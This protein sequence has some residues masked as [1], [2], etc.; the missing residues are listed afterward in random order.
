MKVTV[1]ESD[2]LGSDEICLLCCRSDDRII[3]IVSYIR[4]MDDEELFAKEQE[5]FFKI[6]LSDVYYFE[7]ID[8]KTFVYLEDRVLETALRL[9]ELEEKYRDKMMFRAGKSIIVNLKYIQSASPMLN[10]N[11]LVTMKNSE[12]IIISR[13]YVKEFNQR[14]GMEG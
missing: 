1:K 7:S 14:I 2:K 8:K 12:K 13:R 6:S 11:L 4:G 5:K 3:R 9:Y 10:R